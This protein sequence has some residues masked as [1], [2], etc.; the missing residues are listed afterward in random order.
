[1]SDNAR[2]TEPAPGP[3]EWERKM[4]DLAET[5]GV[6]AACTA[7]AVD[8]MRWTC[9][10]LDHP[11]PPNHVRYCICETWSEWMLEGVV[12]IGC[13]DKDPLDWVGPSDVGDDRG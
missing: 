12:V 4:L 11:V 7:A 6:L 13:G 10:Q 8:Q 9:E 1:M 5:D 3:N 2:V